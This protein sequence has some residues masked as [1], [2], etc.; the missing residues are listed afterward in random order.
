MFKKSIAPLLATLIAYHTIA[1]PLCE[2]SVYR[3]ASRPAAGNLPVPDPRAQPRAV[4]RSP[5]SEEATPVSSLS[6]PSSLGEVID[7]WY[8]TW[9]VGSKQKAA[10]RDGSNRPFVVLLQDV[11]NQAGAQKNE[12]E[13]LRY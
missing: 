10:R 7:T 6:F 9:T 3:Q 8:P 5:S 4:P 1:S 12:A 13:I 11:H 2:A